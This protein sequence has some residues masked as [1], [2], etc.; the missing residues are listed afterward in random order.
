M[1]QI[2]YKI[3]DV[4]Y[5]TETP[6]KNTTVKAIKARYGEKLKEIKIKKIY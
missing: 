3:D 1:Y 5:T 2:I 6:Y 4:T